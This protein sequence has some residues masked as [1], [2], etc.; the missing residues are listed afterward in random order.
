[1]LLVAIGAEVPVGA[2]LATVAWDGS[3][4]IASES[5]VPQALSKLPTASV[6][7]TKR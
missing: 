1:M 2:V 5:V 6:A 3:T 7:T 4:S